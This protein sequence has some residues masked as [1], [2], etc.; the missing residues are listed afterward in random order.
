L[1]VD[2][3]FHFVWQIGGDKATTTLTGVSTLDGGGYEFDTSSGS[4]LTL[5][6]QDAAMDLALGGLDV[7]CDPASITIDKAS[8]DGLVQATKDSAAGQQTFASCTAGDPNDGNDAATFTFRPALGGTPGAI[9][10]GSA[11][12]EGFVLFVSSEAADTNGKT[13]YTGEGGVTIIAAGQ[14]TKTFPSMIS[15]G[16]AG[17]ATLTWNITGDDPIVS[18]GCTIQGEPAT[19]NLVAPH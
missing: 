5:D 9:I 2:S 12:D 16:A 4:F 19:T 8:L 3:T 1:T 7:Q 14:H 13:T 11:D 10:E 6:T 15:A 17:A 18:T